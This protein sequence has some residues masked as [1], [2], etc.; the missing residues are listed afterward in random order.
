MNNGLERKYGLLTAIAMVVG[1]VIGSGVFFKAQ[2]ILT[3]TNGNMPLGILAWI[4]GGCIML[5]CILAFAIMATKYEKV[6]GI[7]DYA[8]AA[9]SKKYGYAVGWFMTFIYYPTLTSVLAWLSARRNY[10][11]VG[12]GRASVLAWRRHRMAG[13]RCARLAS[14]TFLSLRARASVHEAIRPFRPWPCEPFP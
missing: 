8:E 1:I 3:K 2:T 4:V 12:S 10:R 14:G 7:V 6:N 5:A 11:A 13:P 9:V